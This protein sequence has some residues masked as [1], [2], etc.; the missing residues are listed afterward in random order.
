MSAFL[1]DLIVGLLKAFLP[2]AM[3]SSKDTYTVAIEEDKGL[4]KRL[5]ASVKDV[6]GPVLVV[7]VLSLSLVGCGNRTIY[8]P[9]GQPVKLREALKSVKVWVKT[10]D[11]KIEAVEIDVPEGWYI[12]PDK[13]KNPEK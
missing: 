7:C 12:L 9:D 8:I 4:E 3:E 10:K 13:K 5:R 11:G 2:A 1:V 6:W